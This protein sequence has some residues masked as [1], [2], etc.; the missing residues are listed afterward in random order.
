MSKVIIAGSGVIGLSVCEA[1]LD[2]GHEIILIDEKSPGSQTSYGNAGLIADYA[3]SP[4]ANVDTLKKLPSMLVNSCSGISVNYKDTLN[5][6]SYGLHFVKAA[7]SHYQDNRQLISKILPSAVV[8]HK[9]QIE[10]LNAH[11]LVL[12]NGCLHLF[13][14]CNEKESDLNGIVND[15]KKF[16]IECEYVQTHEIE[17]MEPNINISGVVGGIFYPKTQSLL[18]P[19]SH[20]RMLYEKISAHRNFTFVQ[21]KVL[22]FEQQ[23]SNV[24]TETTNGVHEGDQFIICAGIGSNKI[25]EPHNI[26]LPVVSER[27]YHIEFDDSDISITRPVGWQGKY[28]FATPMKGK[29][30]LA[31]T[32]EFAAVNRAPNTKHYDMMKDWAEKLF[33]STGEVKERWMGVRHSTPDGVPVIS[34][35]PQMDRVSV[36]YGHGHLGLTMAAFSGQFVADMVAKRADQELL[37]ALSLSRF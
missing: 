2:D 17:N 32:T 36:C 35:L 21:D 28:F 4:L 6:T 18:S 1:L 30:R 19:A 31:G 20:T 25:L 15:K 29:T 12:K 3:N 22:N 37:N 5:L 7:L 8:A 33:I 9:Q 10:R 26:A 14:E 16:G 11:D 24:F 13:K 23:A 27:G 34:Q